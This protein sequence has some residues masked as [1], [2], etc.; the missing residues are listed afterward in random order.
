MLGPGVCVARV[1]RNGRNF[2]YVSGEDPYL[3][4][5]MAAAVVNGI[6][7]QGVVANVKHWVN[8]NQET[9]RTTVTETVDERT[10]FELYYPPFEG[11]ISAGVGSLMCSYN[12][13]CQNCPAGK[14]GRWSCE[15]PDT[16]YDLKERLGFKGWV[17]SDWGATHSASMNEGLDQEMPGAGHMGDKLKSMVANGTVTMDKVDDSAFRI[18]WPL[19]SVGA[20]DTP[21]YYTNDNNVT[22]VEHNTL[23]RKISSAST[24]LLKNDGILPLGTSVKTIAV[25][26]AEANSPTTHGGGSGQVISYY[27]SSPLTSLRARFGLGPLVR[28]NN[29]SNGAYEHGIDFQNMDKQVSTG[30]TSADECC[31]LCGQRS[32]CNAFTFVGGTCWMKADAKNRKNNSDAVSGIC[33]K[34]PSTGDDCLNGRCVKYADASNISAAVALAKEADVVLV[35]VAT[36]SSEGGDRGDLTLGSQDDLV[37]AIAK[38][39][40]KKTAVIAVTP[41]AVLTPWRD[42]VSAILA[43]LMPGQEYGNAIAEVLF[44]D[45]NPGAK[46]PLTFPSVE[47]ETGFADDQWPGVNRTANYTEALEVGYRWYAAHPKVKP[48]FPF[49]HGLSY[50]AFKYSDLHVEGRSIQ[51]RV[52]NI[53][54]VGGSEVPQLYLKF[55]DSAGE[56]PKQLKGYS[57]ISLGPDESQS[58]KFTLDDRSFSIWDSAKHMWSIV[59]GDFGVMVGS[60]SEDIRLTGTVQ[61][62]SLE[63]L[64]L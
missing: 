58:I 61:S 6:Q 55:P 56:P 10:Q 26:G 15:N 62:S 21:N 16:L 28:H 8:N 5:R 46:L 31:A 60:S 50:T 18:L 42:G 19:F 29:C 32:E 63:T 7:S 1:P 9:D 27:T 2:E 23:A 33:K 64:I 4:Y 59:Q 14:E 34:G 44:G 47:N 38:A 25:I 30:A 51:F 12:K 48:A 49:G 22:S 20:M 3:G 11:A 53:G 52:Q 24:V 45:V 57:K 37:Q 17:M 13:I 39:S 35:F 43:P 36:S 41:G 54:K 40:G